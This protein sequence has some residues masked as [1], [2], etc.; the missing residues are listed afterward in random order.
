M[1]KSKP[2]VP[3]PP[4]LQ[5]TNP[6]IEQSGQQ[7]S[8][9]A[10]RFAN[11]LNDP[12]FGPSVETAPEL[13][14]LAIE[15]FQLQNQGQFDRQ[16]QDLVNRLEGLGALT[17]TTTADAL[18]QNL[19]EFQRQQ[20]AVG[21]AAA[22][23]DIQRALENRLRFGSLGAQTSQALGG[24]GTSQL[25]IS[26]AARQ[27]QFENQLAV[28]ELNRDSRGG[29]F[30]ALTGGLGGALGGIALAPFTGGSSLAL[31]LGGGLLGGAAG[32]FGPSGAG[33]QLFSAG[34]GLAGSS[35]QSQN[36]FNAR[37]KITGIEDFPSYLD[38]ANTR[39]LGSQR[40]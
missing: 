11:P 14:R 1:S 32:A 23:A 5:T 8:S 40:F 37:R 10:S 17:G 34:A 3:S 12:F 26:N 9:L 24:L 36:P 21:G 30:G 39:I 6:F 27:A 16:Q 2:S 22:I 33:G 15:N 28:D 4:S 29:I 7:L 31:G 18:G 20:T 35:F 25:Q 38:P 19:Q 13:S